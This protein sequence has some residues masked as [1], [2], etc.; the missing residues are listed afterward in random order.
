MMRLKN[1]GIVNK[2]KEKKDN[3]I[4]KICASAHIFFNNSIENIFFKY[5][6]KLQSVCVRDIMAKFRQ[7]CQSG[8]MCSLGK[9]VW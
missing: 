1:K 6:K 8:L 3:L 2:T 9:R 7:R 5:Q 4:T